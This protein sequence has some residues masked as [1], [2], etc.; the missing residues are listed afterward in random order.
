MTKRE[1]NLESCQFDLETCHR[2]SKFHG[3]CVNEAL[4]FGCW[5][6]LFDVTNWNQYRSVCCSWRV[7]LLSNL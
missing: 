2:S 3:S 7:E 6:G 5:R 1:K 4:S